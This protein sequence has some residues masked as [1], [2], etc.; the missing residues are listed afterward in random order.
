M[1]VNLMTSA[2]NSHHKPSP[3]SQ[4]TDVLRQTEPSE[5]LSKTKNSRPGMLYQSKI[6]LTPKSP[7]EEKVVN[8]F[9]EKDPKI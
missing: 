1:N 4:S 8:K 6:K 2:R 5:N 9:S 7:R 3:L